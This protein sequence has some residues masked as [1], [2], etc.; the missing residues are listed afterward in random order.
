VKQ[1][2]AEAV[3]WFNR[4]ADAANL[5]TTKSTVF[6][7]LAD[8]YCAAGK[9]D[10]AMA[11]LEKVCDLYP[12]ESDA[13]VSL[14]AWQVWFGKTQ[15]FEKIRHDYL[16]SVSNGDTAY[17]DEAVAKL[18]SL[19]PSSDSAMLDKAVGLARRGVELRKGTPGRAWYYLSLGMIEY[20]SGQYTNAEQHLA[21][22][23][24]T[25]GKYQDVLPT[26][27]FFRAMCLF[28][29]NRAGEARQLFNET[30]SLMPAFPQ[31]PRRP[32][33]DGKAATHDVVIA[34]LAYR[35]AKELLSGDKTLVERGN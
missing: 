12:R 28:Q 26:A 30:T 33:L 5:G 9:T 23:I 34:W 32:V 31:N 20:R 19:T 7:T 24:Q 21:T 4:A 22:A 10:E 29:E 16:R 35:E 6:K 15:A 17:I 18:Y 14:A 1:D 3:K 11:T 13:R 8:C 25:A 2:E 27:G